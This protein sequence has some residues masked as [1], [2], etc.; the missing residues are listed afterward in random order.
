MA[1]DAYS[2]NFPETKLIKTNLHDF[3]DKKDSK[4]GKPANLGQK[5][6]PQDH[7]YGMRIEAN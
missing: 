1:P 5:Q 6:F 2:N 7:V 3:F 4:L